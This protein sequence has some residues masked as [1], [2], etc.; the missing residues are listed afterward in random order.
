M[1]TNDITQPPRIRISRR[2]GLAFAAGALA[3]G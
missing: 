3:V 1:T 2:A